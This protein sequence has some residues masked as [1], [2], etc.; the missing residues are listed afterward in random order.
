M[1]ACIR[2]TTLLINHRPTIQDAREPAILIANCVTVVLRNSWSAS[3][4]MERFSVLKRLT[5]CVSS[6]SWSGFRVAPHGPGQGIPCR[7]RERLRKRGACHGM[8]QE[9]NH[10]Q[11][12][13]RVDVQHLTLHFARLVGHVS[14]VQGPPVI[15]LDVVRAKAHA[16]GLEFLAV[17]AARHV[18]ERA[19]LSTCWRLYLA[20]PAQHLPETCEVSRT[21]VLA[22]AYRLGLAA[23]GR[24]AVGACGLDALVHARQVGRQTSHLS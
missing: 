7:Q 14:I 19:S 17:A 13:G 24:R 16:Q 12:G 6:R 3:T 10:Y 20:P 1:P 15:A 9:L 5:R 18:C 22:L 4:S 11:L 8:R 2:A 23:L 21:D